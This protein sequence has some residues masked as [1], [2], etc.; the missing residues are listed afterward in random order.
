MSKPFWD[1]LP[2]DI[3]SVLDQAMQR[4]T[5][6]ANEIAEEENFV[7]AGTT[8][9]YEPTS[10]ER[11]ALINALLPVHKEMADR[12]GAKTFEAVYQAAGFRQP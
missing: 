5:A 3:R 6:Y 1:G 4:T 7:A 10:L 9:V 12:M 2:P 8:E 11:D